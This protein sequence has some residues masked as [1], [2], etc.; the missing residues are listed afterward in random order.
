MPERPLVTVGLRDALAVLLVV[1][2]V[3]AATLAAGNAARLGEPPQTLL[4]FG[5]AV[6]AWGLPALGAYRLLASAA[7]WVT[8]VRVRPRYGTAVLTALGGWW[9]AWTGWQLWV[10]LALT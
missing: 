2:G 4:P 5:R 1:V 9:F 7:V 3:V 8:V 10:L 6:A